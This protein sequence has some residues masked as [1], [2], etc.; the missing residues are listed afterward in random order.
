MRNELDMKA[1]RVPIKMNLK[2]HIQRHTIIRMLK[3]KEKETILKSAK[4]KLFT[5]KTS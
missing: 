2:R 1:L 5:K 4:G 3:V